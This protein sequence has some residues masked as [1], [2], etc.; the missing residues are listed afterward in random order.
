AIKS[1]VQ[2]QPL[3]LCNDHCSLGYSKIKIEGKPFCCYKC[4]RCPEGKIANQT[5]DLIIGGIVSLIYMMSNLITFKRIPSEELLDDPIYCHAN[6]QPL[7]LCN[8]DCSL[9]YSKIKIEGKPFC[10]Y[11][12]LRCPEGKIANQTVCLEQGHTFLHIPVKLT[13]SGSSF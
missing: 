7:S 11:K 3:S 12:C 1:K 6:T 8:D 2:N 4:L 13:H 10:C 9:G 5:G